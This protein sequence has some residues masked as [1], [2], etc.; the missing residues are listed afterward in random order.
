MSTKL[1]ND[2]GRM[3]GVLSR[4]EMTDSTVEALMQLQPYVT[5]VNNVK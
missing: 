1:T 3:F 2:V 4:E 5:K